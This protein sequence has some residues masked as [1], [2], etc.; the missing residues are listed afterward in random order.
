MKRQKQQQHL[1][2]EM[3]RLPT[4]ILYIGQTGGIFHT[5]YKEHMQAIRNSN[6]NSG[7]SSHV[8]SMEHTYG[9]ITDT[10]DII[11]THKKGKRL[12]ILEK[13]HIYKICKN[14]FLMT[15]TNIDTHNPI[16]RTLHK[17]NTC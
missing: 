12:N 8:L 16:F 3:P 14:D 6:S 15:D 2:N 5:R 13:Y 10:T 1:P 7:Y 4:K 17:M 11:R 9:I